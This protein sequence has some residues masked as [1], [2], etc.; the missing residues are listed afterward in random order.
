MRVFEAVKTLRGWSWILGAV[1]LAPIVFFLYQNWLFSQWA[2][3]LASNGEFVCGTGIIAIFI[4]CT[5]V[6]TC[7]SAV[8]TFI[9]FLGYLEIDKPRPRKRLFEVLVIGS[10]LVAAGGTCLTLI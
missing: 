5:V 7:L 8:A 3:K 10:I 9:G 4:L 1:S 6:A 2:K